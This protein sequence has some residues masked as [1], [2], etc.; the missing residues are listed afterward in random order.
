MGPLGAV[1]ALS[2]LVLCG[3]VAPLGIK[4]HIWTIMVD[5][6]VKPLTPYT[7]QMLLS[8]LTT[9]PTQ[10]DP[11]LSF[12]SCATRSLGWN[13]LSLNGNN[14]EVQSLY[15]TALAQEQGVRFTS[16]YV[17]KFCSPTRASF[18]TGR[19]A[20]HGIQETNLGFV[21]EVACNGNLTMIGAKMKQAGYVT[22]QIGKWCANSTLPRCSARPQPR[23]RP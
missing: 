4:P 1:L 21:S 22:A 3:G 17:Y 12:P 20:G 6:Y 13:G 9:H 23:P 16:H 10:I 5:E 8:V 19:I 18:L 2:L 7:P 14:E 11:P 15:T